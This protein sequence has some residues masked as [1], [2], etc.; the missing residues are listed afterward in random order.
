[1]FYQGAVSPLSSGPPRKVLTIALGS[2]LD[3]LTV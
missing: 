3:D 2:R 1:M